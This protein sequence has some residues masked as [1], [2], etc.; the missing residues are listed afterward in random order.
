MTWTVQD[1]RGRTL[2]IV[3]W[4]LVVI[5]VAELGSVVT[6]VGL[7]AA[8]AP[9]TELWPGLV[10]IVLAA[11][12]VA[13]PDGPIGLLTLLA[14][15]GWWLVADRTAPWTAALVVALAALVFHVALAHAAAGPAGVAIAPA[16]ARSVARD[17]GVV[18]ALTGGA[19]LV[20][21]V[22]DGSG[23]RAPSYLIGVALILIGLLPWIALDGARN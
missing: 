13:V 6:M 12:A 4:G 7:A 23:L 5:G 8:H 19:A 15:G 14:Y 11:L 16:V 21:A 9:R 20:V 2:A 18:A 1:R 22:L 10:V 3:T 17:V